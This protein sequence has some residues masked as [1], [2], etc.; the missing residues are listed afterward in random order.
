V[1]EKAI[2]MFA[3]LHPEKKMVVNRER[4]SSTKFFFLQGEPDGFLLNEEEQVEAIIEVKRST[5]E[6]LKTKYQVHAYMG[7]FSVQKAW[8]IV[9]SNNKIDP[10]MISRD[11][12]ILNFISLGYYLGFAPAIANGRN[13]RKLKPEERVKLMALAASN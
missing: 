11:D 2:Q 13:F 12:S 10:E 1:E 3:K 4:C 5:R 7:I 8:I 6:S 9:Y